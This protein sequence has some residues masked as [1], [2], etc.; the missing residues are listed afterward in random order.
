MSR[1][2]AW[3]ELSMRVTLTFKSFLFFVYLPGKG[4]INSIKGTGGERRCVL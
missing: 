3:L 4:N 1:K 2:S